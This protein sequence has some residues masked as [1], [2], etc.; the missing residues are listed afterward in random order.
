MKVAVYTICK[1][2]SI[3]VDRFMDSVQDANYVIILD[4]GSTD[5]TVE[6][7]RNRG[8][9]VHQEDI[10]P[11][12]FDTA[13]NKNLSMVPKD[14]DICISIDLDEYL[15]EGWREELEYHWVPGVTRVNY[16]YSL[17]GGEPYRHHKIH[18]RFGYSWFG[19]VH[20]E[21]RPSIP[22]NEIW[23]DIRIEHWPDQSKDRSQYIPLLEKVVREDPN[24]SRAYIYLVVECINN[25]RKDD[26][27]KWADTFFQID[28]SWDVDRSYV[29]MLV[30][31]IY[32]ERGEKQL[33]L[34]WRM[35]SV[36]EANWWRESWYSLAKALE[37]YGEKILSCQASKNALNLEERVYVSYSNTEAWT[38]EIYHLAAR[39]SLDKRDAQSYLTR[40]C[41]SFPDDR[42]L[43]IELGKLMS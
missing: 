12:R 6:K 41:R 24:N 14:A 19:I 25:D 35:R 38:G 39:C 18:S 22:E 27:I 36:V 31:D 9:R 13:R 34:F 30:A 17:M 11:W 42:S 7:L 15:C 29:S 28:H 8:A 33:D 1:N 23:T 40:G 26:A 37:K 43:A 4:T 5:D 20:E 2:E 32:S 3:H 16:W 10:Q 21:L